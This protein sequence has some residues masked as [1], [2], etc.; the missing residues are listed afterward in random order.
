MGDYLDA[1]CSN[2]SAMK[3][4][5]G[6]KWQSAEEASFDTWIKHYRQDENSPNVLSSYYLQGTVIGWMLDM[7]IR[8]TTATTK[9]LDDA[10]RTLY[11]ETFVK[12]NRGYTDEDFER[13][14]ASIIGVGVTTQI[15]DSR[16][17]GR[18]EVD[19]DK[20]LGYAG[21]KIVPKK[22][23]TE[24]GFLGVKIRQESGRLVLS[25]IL[26]ESPA[27]TSGLVVS[28]EIIALDGLRMDSSRLP[29]YVANREPETPV[30]IT[31]LKTWYF[32]RIDC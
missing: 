7:E 16:V 3:S 4:L 2:I 19:F 1:F 8:K 31:S 14:C 29:W 17:R 25:G 9:N 32:A 30:K 13:I 6:S 15:F 18:Q 26:S 23:Q 11:Q 21:L 27:E 20:Y 10:L 22:P 24:Q 5:P 12:E 28:D